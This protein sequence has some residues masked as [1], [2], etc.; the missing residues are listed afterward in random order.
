MLDTQLWAQGSTTLLIGMGI[1]FTFLVILIFAIMISAKV[2]T[3][4]DRLF[5][6]LKEETKSSKKSSTDE[7]EVALAVAVAANKA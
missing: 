5:P 2:V 6:P 4:I 3:L 1:V 7:S